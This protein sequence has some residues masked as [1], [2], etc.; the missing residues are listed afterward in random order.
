MDIFLQKSTYRALFLSS[1]GLWEWGWPFSHCWFLSYGNHSCCLWYFSP[2]YAK[3]GCTIGNEMRAEVIHTASRKTQVQL[4]LFHLCPL[5]T[6]EEQIEISS[7]ACGPSEDQHDSLLNCVG[8]AMGAKIKYLMCSALRLV[9]YCCLRAQA[10]LD[11]TW[12]KTNMTSYFRVTLHFCLQEIHYRWAEQN[13]DCDL[14]R[15]RSK[16]QV[17]TDP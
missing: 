11:D 4:A 8:H 2:F 7:L 5:M 9:F 3:V 17:W 12:L 15:R 14:C 6:R 16:E 1:S 13:L 10:H